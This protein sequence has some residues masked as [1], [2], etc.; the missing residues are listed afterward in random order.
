MFFHTVKQNQETAPHFLDPYTA[1]I[2]EGEGKKWRDIKNF[3]TFLSTKFKD[4]EHPII[5]IVSFTL[6]LIAAG[7]TAL[8]IFPEDPLIASLI[9]GAIN[10]ITVVTHYSLQC[11][12]ESKK[13]AEK[14]KAEILLREII[15]SYQADKIDELYHQCIPNIPRD[16]G[17]QQYLNSSIVPLEK[18]FS[19]LNDIDED[20]DKVDIEIGSHSFPA[21][22]NIFKEIGR[23]LAPLT[24]YQKLGYFIFAVSP[25]IL[26]SIKI[27]GI[28]P[29]IASV[30]LGIFDGAKKY[31]EEYTKTPEKAEMKRFRKHKLDILK[32]FSKAEEAFE[33][34]IHQSLEKLKLKKLEEEIKQQLPI[35]TKEKQAQRQRKIGWGKDH[36]TRIL[37][38]R[39]GPRNSRGFLIVEA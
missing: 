19:A 12:L 37:P 9:I 11:W 23:R 3:S 21:E 14:E 17:V 20:G 8:E 36:G 31:I 30:A 25:P 34:N 4:E 15:Y 22:S 24:T 2:C 1:L 6:P 32:S 26:H 28:S 18:H 29:V 10:I 16:A 39:I 27:L 33:K 7:I 35:R 38:S 5:K 13:K